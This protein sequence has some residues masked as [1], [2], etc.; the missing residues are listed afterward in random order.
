[1][2]IS[3]LIMIGDNQVD[4]R[5]PQEVVDAIEVVRVSITVTGKPVVIEANGEKVEYSN[6]NI[7]RLIDLQNEYRGKVAQATGQ[8]RRYAAKIR[9]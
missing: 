6:V 1:M 3:T 9:W 5:N 4:I 8:R 2:A 7:Q